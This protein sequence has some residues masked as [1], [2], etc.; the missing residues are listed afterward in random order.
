MNVLL[1]SLSHRKHRLQYKSPLAVSSQRGEPLLCMVWGGHLWSQQVGGF[2]P[3]NRPTLAR[4]SQEALPHI[5]RCPAAGSSCPDLHILERHQ[6]GW[7]SSRQPLG[8][9][10]SGSRDMVL[11]GTCLLLHVKV[12]TH[13]R[14]GCLCCLPQK[15]T[16]VGHVASQRSLCHERPGARLA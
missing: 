1:S 7:M 13:P 10:Y 8:Q 16:V 15:N 6:L 2:H 11:P 5:P 4:L 12:S 9:R 14:E 3:G